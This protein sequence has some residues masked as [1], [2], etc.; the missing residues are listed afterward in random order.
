M[1]GSF[2]SRCLSF[3]A[4]CACNSYSVLLWKVR[5]L[6]FVIWRVPEITC[7]DEMSNFASYEHCPRF[8]VC[9]HFV[10]CVKFGDRFAF[11]DATAFT[12]TWEL[13]FAVRHVFQFA[14]GWTVGPSV[15]RCQRKKPF[16][17]CVAFS[18]CLV[19]LCRAWIRICLSQVH[20]WCIVSFKVCEFVFSFSATF[21]DCL[22]T[23]WNVK[24]V[25][26]LNCVYVCCDNLWRQNVRN[27]AKLRHCFVLAVFV[28]V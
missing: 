20:S 21:C 3:V 11:C 10:L 7:R 4:V 19:F 14:L 17:W 8:A 13:F 28:T 18:V 24:K 15:S 5:T 6:E 16:Q 25:H 2:D 22:I 23:V 26:Q 1:I 9:F 12:Y 27:L